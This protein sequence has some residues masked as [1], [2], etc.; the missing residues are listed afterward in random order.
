[1]STVFRPGANLCL[2][3]F[4]CILIIAGSFSL[5]THIAGFV[6][7]VIVL[8]VFLLLHSRLFLVIVEAGVLLLVF[9]LLMS[10]LL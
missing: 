2:G 9:F 10:T 6:L 3:V 4:G 7:V 8:L 1:M 5:V